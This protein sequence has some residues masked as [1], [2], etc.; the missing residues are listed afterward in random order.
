MKSPLREKAR[1]RIFKR[2]PVETAIARTNR[3]TRRLARSNPTLIE[4]AFHERVE[5]C[6][7]LWPHLFCGIIGVFGILSCGSMRVPL[8]ARPPVFRSSSSGNVLRI[9]S[10]RCVPTLSVYVSRLAYVVLEIQFSPFFWNIIFLKSN[11]PR[12]TFIYIPHFT[13]L[14]VNCHF[15][16]RLYPYK[17]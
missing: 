1:I 2:S 5:A 9:C 13:Q 6:R 12:W 7:L 10:S 16:S 11:F 17:T 14:I 15:G 8:A 3:R 4:T